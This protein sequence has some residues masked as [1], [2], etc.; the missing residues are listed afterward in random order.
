MEWWQLVFALII[1][2]AYVVKHILSL[3]QERQAT[4]QR[5]LGKDIPQR[6]EV[7][8]TDEE[9]THQRTELDRRIEEVVELR[10]EI[11]ETRPV[12]TRSIPMPMPKPPL[13][14]RPVP[15]Y[16][17]QVPSQQRPLPAL[18]RRVPSAPTPAPVVVAVPTPAAPIDRKVLAVA[19]PPPAKAENPIARQ[20]R[21]LLKDRQTLAAAFV[22]REIFDRPVCGRRRRPPLAG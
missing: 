11:E 5:E 13:V 15:R 12:R 22:L 16:E 1:I 7:A 4:E 21:E 17:P 18:I 9:L 6:V 8:P 3:Q 2:A 14:K 19:L 10:T 20:L